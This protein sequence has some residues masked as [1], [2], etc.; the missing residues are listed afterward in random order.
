MFFC[1]PIVFGCPTR[2]KPEGDQTPRIC[3]RCHNA[4]T[5]RVKSR[6]WFELCFVPLVPMNK[7]HL[8]VCTICQWSVPIQQGWEPALPGYGWQ[9]PVQ[10]EWQSPPYQ[11]MSPPPN[12]AE[13][14]YQP[15]Y[16]NYNAKPN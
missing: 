14:G 10:G 2:M 6:M 1:L 13:H 9:N 12:A 7:E 15:Q 5:I 3:P 11:Q 16:Q 4:S 8:W